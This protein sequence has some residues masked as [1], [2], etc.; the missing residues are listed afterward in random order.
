MKNT[1]SLKGKLLDRGRLLLAGI[2]AISLLIVDN[3]YF[4]HIIMIICLILAIGY[5]AMSIFKR[6]STKDPKKS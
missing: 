3:L 4:D 1:E 2:A 5:A 6:V